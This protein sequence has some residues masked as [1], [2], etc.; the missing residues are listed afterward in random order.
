[1][2]SG[3]T[4]NLKNSYT[5]KAK[6]PNGTRKLWFLEKNALLYRGDGSKRLADN[7]LVAL[8]L[9]IAESDPSEH[10]LILKLVVNLINRDN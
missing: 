7:A 3:D 1:L 2:L 6:F 10:D 5:C 8:T 9:M 4:F